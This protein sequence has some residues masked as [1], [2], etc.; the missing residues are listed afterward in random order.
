MTEIT[1]MYPAAKTWNPFKGCEFDCLYC[2]PSFQAQAK[3]QKHRCLECYKY[4]PHEHP[5]RLDS[6]PSVMSQ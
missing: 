6:I 5:E 3:R 2:V 1:N 4:Q